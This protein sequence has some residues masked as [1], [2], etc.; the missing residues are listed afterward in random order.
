MA[1]KT[2][3][4][5]RFWRFV[6]KD[7][8]VP[9]GCPELGSCWNW[10]GRIG[11]H[12]YSLIS[13]GEGRSLLAHRYSYELHCG[14]IPDETP[15]VLHHCDNPPCPNPVH[16]FVGTKQANS[17]DMVSKGRCKTPYLQGEAHAKA[18]LTEASVLAIRQSDIDGVPRKA[19]AVRF[20]ISEAYVCNILARR[21]WQHI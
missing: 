4:Q 21:R 20:D 18:K 9:V 17:L 5:E 13:D 19:I 15:C 8:P 7:G 6:D 14:S 10:A 11:S 16:L 3:I 1:Y 12:G 2:P